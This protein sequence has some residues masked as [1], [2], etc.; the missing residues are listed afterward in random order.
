MNVSVFRLIQPGTVVRVVA[1][2]R[3]LVCSPL[4]GSSILH[5]K[6]LSQGENLHGVL[7]PA[8]G[9][10]QEEEDLCGVGWHN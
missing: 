7:F 5:G 6:D 4:H 1:C 2:V 3:S 9:S 10:H 8:S